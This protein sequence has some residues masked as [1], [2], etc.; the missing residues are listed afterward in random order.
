MISF[1][2][3]LG[4]IGAVLLLALNAHADGYEPDLQ[5]GEEINYVCA[6]CHGEFAQGSK[7]GEYPR[8]AAQPADYLERQLLLFRERKRPNIPML[9]HIQE[10]QMPASEVKDVSAYIAS[11]E[12]PN[13]LPPIDEST[14]NPLDRLFLAKKTIN[15]PRAEG[16]I[17]T[18]R[19][20]YQKECGSCHGRTGE[21]DDK[22]NVPMLSGQYTEYLWR[23][24]EKFREGILI[25]DPDDPEFRLLSLFTDKE[26][27]DMFAWLSVADD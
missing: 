25:H 21:G 1:F 18:G 12:L 10:Q 4:P 26:L 11:I 22:Y 6:G 19:R 14:Y 16:D 13:K 27:Q 23:Q 24:V 5:I 8:L 3:K 2:R 9:E 7:N 20:Q 15:I 17:E